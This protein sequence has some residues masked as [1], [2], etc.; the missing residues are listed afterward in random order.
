MPVLA[1][2][3]STGPLAAYLIPPRHP[4]SYFCTVVSASLD[5][6][7]SS[8]DFSNLRRPLRP[9]L[10]SSISLESADRRTARSYFRIALLH[11]FSRSATF[12]SVSFLSSPALMLF[13][14]SFLILQQGSSRSTH[15]CKLIS[16]CLFRL[17]LTKS[18]RSLC[19]CFFAS[20]ISWDSNLFWVTRRYTA[21]TSLYQISAVALVLPS[22]AHLELLLLPSVLPLDRMLITLLVSSDLLPSRLDR[23]QLLP[24]TSAEQQRVVGR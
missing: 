10:P 8:S 24:R 9:R 23:L 17:T 12:H 7:T 6:S 1:F 18:S 21:K 4:P 13:L 22:R 3:D 20:S 2:E 11:S 19:L 5:R 15:S 14:D 16:G